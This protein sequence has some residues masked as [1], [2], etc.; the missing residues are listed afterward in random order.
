MPSIGY[1]TTWPSRDPRPLLKWQLTQ[2]NI[3]LSTGISPCTSAC[4]G[5]PE[6]KTPSLYMRSP[7]F[8]A[9]SGDR[10]ARLDCIE[11]SANEIPDTR[12][13]RIDKIP[14]AIITLKAVRFSVILFTS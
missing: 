4:I 12:V 8:K 1:V 2:E 6:A 11:L 13:S 5:S 14:D 3:V 7:I 9:S 10:L